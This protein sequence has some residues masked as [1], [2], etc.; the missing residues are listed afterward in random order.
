LRPAGLQQLG[1]RPAKP[2]PPTLRIAV[3]FSTSASR[4]V[5]TPKKVQEETEKHAKELQQ[6]ILQPKKPSEV[7][8]SSTT[9][10]MFEKSNPEAPEKNMRKELA[11][12]LVSN[13]GQTF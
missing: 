8:T 10:P 5:I 2:V 1:L 4:L 3:C 12:E 6:E 11:E 13:L 7:T 9:T